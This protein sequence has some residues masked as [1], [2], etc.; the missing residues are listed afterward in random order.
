[1]RSAW[2]DRSDVERMIT[3]GAIRDAKSVAA[4]A[5]FVLRA[6]LA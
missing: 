2:F 5:L 4:Y 3:E 6:S 1:M